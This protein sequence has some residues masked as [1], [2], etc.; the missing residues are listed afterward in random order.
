MTTRSDLPAAVALPTAVTI[1]PERGVWSGLRRRAREFRLI[2]QDPVL[3]TGLLVVGSFLFFFVIYPIGR[4]VYQGFVA[5]DGSFSLE[6]INRY[7]DPYFRAYYWNTFWS[8][9]RMGVLTATFGTA[10]GFIFAFTAVRCHPPFPRLFHIIALL[11]ILSPPFAM[12]LATI[13]LFGRN[14][15]ITRQI[16]GMRFPP[17]SND[18]Y[19]M[20]GLVFVQTITFFSI[21]YLILRS[22]LERL[23]PSME[24][25]AQSMGASKF[26][27]FRTV[28][29]PLLVPGL[30]ASFLLL[31]V[32]S[33]ADLGNPLLLSGNVQVLS[34]E[35][36]LAVTGEFNQ[37][38][39]SALSFVLLL[40]TLSVFILQ[41]YWV[42]RRSYIAVTGKPSGGQIQVEDRFLR[43]TFL[44]VCYLIVAIILMLY[45]SIIVGS[46]TALWGINYTFVSSHY[47]VALTR[48]LPAILDTTFLSAVA[49]PIAGVLGMVVA[50][51]VVRKTFSGKEML[52]FT[53]NLGGA[54]PGTIL[55]IGFILAFIRGPGLL[56]V[57]V[58]L[59]LA[60]YLTGIE[61]EFR[62]P[63]WGMRLGMLAAGCGLGGYLALY[64]QQSVA[65]ANYLVYWLGW[66]YLALALLT[67]W[68]LWRA[69]HRGLALAPVIM[70]LVLF[71]WVFSPDW[72]APL[73]RTGRSLDNRQLSRI[74]TSTAE[75]ILVFWRVP[76][77]FIGMAY[78]FVATFIARAL[79]GWLRYPIITIMLLLAT[80]VTFAQQPLAIVGT[81]T[82][83][84]AAY[85][86]RSL[87]AS[88]RAGVAA[89]HQIDP[90]IEEASA[91]LGADAQ[92][93]FRK[94]TMPLILPSFVAGLIYSFAVH[95]TSLS[96]IIF[97]ISP[98]WRILAAEILSEVEQGGVSIAAAYSVIL[99]LI[100]L[101]SIGLIYFITGRAFAGR[102]DVDLSI[103]GT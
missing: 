94:V 54:V 28:T 48:G 58:F 82:I 76:L 64:G 102:G 100:V 77:V 97:L 50:Y 55:G 4:V 36:Y 24:E 73:A 45:A 98:K 5:S 41:R 85:A 32:E 33:L 79:D 87:P 60:F 92:Y 11:P 78:V 96:A 37:Q 7:V 86:V 66:G 42:S 43:W 6:Y 44:I 57:P 8:T 3:A 39:G 84:I 15:L 67:A 21:S 20:D 27:I 93:T 13:L 26:H 53:S 34:A 10:V 31:F 18:I 65:A 89:L 16:L 25:A 23:D 51:L 38:K 46:L 2:A 49:T 74:V 63:R 9:I 69:G 47:L 101:A 68:P 80:A 12:A 61:R 83:I 22:M 81:S 90:S 56:F 35:I 70:G 59:F 72:M 99:I 75:Y 103:R 29:L 30:A 71:V 17:G 19:G 14:G 95:M 1:P 91:G 88:V 52:D 62:S 40:P